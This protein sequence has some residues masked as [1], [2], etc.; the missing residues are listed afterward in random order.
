LNKGAEILKTGL[1]R[2]WVT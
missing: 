1:Q 2:V